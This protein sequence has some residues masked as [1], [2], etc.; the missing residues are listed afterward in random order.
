MPKSLYSK[1]KASYKARALHIK[2]H[3]S[4][5]IIPPSYSYSRCRSQN[6]PCMVILSAGGKCSGCVHAARPCDLVVTESDCEFSHSACFVTTWVPLYNIYIL[7]SSVSLSKPPENISLYHSQF[8]MLYYSACISS[9]SLVSICL[10]ACS[11]SI[12][13]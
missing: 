7:A 12:I 6:K 2:L 1:S 10:N 5:C 9:I 4:C 3:S 13:R 11:Y 8:S